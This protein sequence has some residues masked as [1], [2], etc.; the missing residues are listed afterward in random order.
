M[1]VPLYVVAYLVRRE[2]AS[3]RKSPDWWSTSKSAALSGVRLVHRLDSSHSALGSRC[4]I[5][6]PDN[7]TASARAS[8]VGGIVTTERLGGLQID[9]QLELGGLLEGEIYVH[10]AREDRV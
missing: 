4:A 8:S 10:G 5:V 2:I 9:D 7:V 3:T 1:L 6:K